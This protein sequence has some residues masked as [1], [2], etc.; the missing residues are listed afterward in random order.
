MVPNRI[1]LAIG[2]QIRRQRNTLGM[3]MSDL[4]TNIGASEFEIAQFE[5]GTK[6]INAP[7][8]VRICKLFG[9]GAGYFFDAFV[10]DL[11]NQ[12]GS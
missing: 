6:R 10:L 4:S 5:N 9:V 12:T 7:A 2:A 1:D 8:L 3:S 11:E